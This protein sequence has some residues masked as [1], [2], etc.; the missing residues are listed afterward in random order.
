MQER[1]PK[2][3]WPYLP[4]KCQQDPHCPPAHRDTHCLSL[5]FI[6]P[7]WLGAKAPC[8]PC[9]IKH[10][11]PPDLQWRSSQ[12]LVYPTAPSLPFA[13]MGFRQ[14]TTFLKNELKSS[15]ED[16]VKSGK[17]DCGILHLCTLVWEANQCIKPLKEG[18]L[19]RWRE[20]FLQI[21]CPCYWRALGAEYNQ[22]SSQSFRTKM[23]PF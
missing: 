23:E 5:S 19:C 17:M 1:E 22:T 9:G 3:Q 21:S 8:W 7:L 10:L 20:G 6:V 2:V 15:P 4:E 11:V 13:C 14:H 16:L 12:F 18:L